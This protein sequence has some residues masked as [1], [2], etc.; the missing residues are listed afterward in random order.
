VSST[1]TVG[2]F[3]ITSNVGDAASMVESLRPEE[4]DSKEP[5]ILVDKGKPVKQEEPDKLSKAASELGKK[6]GEA[7][8]KA[9]KA[10]PIPDKPKEEAKPEPEEKP[11][12]EPEPKE[13]AAAE[14][15]E[16]DEDEDV[17]LT[18]K[19][20]RRIEKATKQAAEAKRQARE[21]E[22]R[23]ERELRD[24]RAQVEHV[25][26]NVAPQPR[27]ESRRAAQAVAPQGDPEPEEGDF[28]L[29]KDFVKAL[30]AWQWRQLDAQRTMEQRRHSLAVGVASAESQ[31]SKHV[32]AAFQDADIRE[33]IS[34]DVLAMEPS[35]RRA[36]G[37]RLSPD[38]VI[39]D[40]L[41]RAGEKA[42]ALMLYLSENANEL[43]R[44]RA[45]RTSSECQ[46]EMRIL[47]RTIGPR[48]DATSG[49]SPAAQGSGSKPESSKAKPPVQPVTGK[50]SIA[51]G[52]DGP[53]PG[54]DF[55]AWYRRTNQSS[56]R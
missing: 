19:Q 31:F 27:E 24:L 32:K 22:L 44:L 42:P 47:A 34:P 21:S 15:E 14:P 28:E 8:A 26:R 16:E 37:V 46:M 40:E 20:R 53:R 17:P 45:L 9:R 5:R 50:P 49:T 43:Q 12:E 2:D 7:A 30:T 18:D 1:V 23:H 25:A 38:N 51:S 52:D 29:H 48:G 11:E 39:A 56:K 33:R 36:P 55:D 6:G 10:K 54:E 3:E 35:W 41:F 13:A 4:P